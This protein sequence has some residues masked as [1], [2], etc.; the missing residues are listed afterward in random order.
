VL[1]RL[2]D[3]MHGD[4]LRGTWFLEA[5]FGS[6]SPPDERATFAT[7]ED[8]ADWISAHHSGGARALAVLGGNGA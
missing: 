8:V 1:V 3:E 5:A 4:E 7:L 6:L 2:Q